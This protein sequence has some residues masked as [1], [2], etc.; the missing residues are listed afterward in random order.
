MK[1]LFLTTSRIDEISER[2]IYIDLMLKFSDE[3]HD[4]FIVTP[5]ERRYKQKTRLIKK[6]KNVTILMICTF[7]IQKTNVLEKSLSTLLIEH[8]FIRGIKKHFS[9]VCFDI[10]LYSTPPITFTK[11]ISCIKQ[12]CGTRSYLLLKDIFPQNAVDLGMIRKGGLL[13][14]YFLNKEKELYEI[15]DY[16]GCMSPASVE[17][18]L[19]HNPEIDHNKVEVNPNSLGQF[20][21]IITQ[22]Q[23]SS[24]RQQFKI[25]YDSTVFIYG[26]NLGK[27]QGVDFI[28]EFLNSQKEENRDFFISCWFRNRIF[29]NKILVQSEAAS[30]CTTFIRIAKK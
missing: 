30:K 5:T 17:Y 27:P 8:Q 20:E 24:I 12:K 11:V 1:I 7:N 9:E 25:P 22:Q 15:S 13:H 21:E 6:D 14:R 26:G 2:G 16:I 28:V 29:K 3:G 23:K 18:I 19:N 4:V 10:V